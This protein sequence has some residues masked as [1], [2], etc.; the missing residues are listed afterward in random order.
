MQQLR[1]L[2]LDFDLRDGAMGEVGSRRAF[3]A[4]GRKDALA[5][6]RS[7]T[8]HWIAKQAAALAPGGRL[9]IVVGDGLVGNRMVDALGPTVESIRASGLHV[10]A[11]A[12]ADRPDHA[13]ETIRIE[14]M[15]MAE[16]PGA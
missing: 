16:R 8:D 2:W 3:R 4:Q 14:H 6:W 9:V 11:R 1:S 15:I 7:D 12:S 13:R 5:R 10:V